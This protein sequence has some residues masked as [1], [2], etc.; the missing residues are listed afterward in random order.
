MR[1]KQFLYRFLYQQNPSPVLLDDYVANKVTKE[2]FDRA[3]EQWWKNPDSPPDEQMVEEA[4][5]V[6]KDELG[7]QAYEAA[8]AALAQALDACVAEEL[9]LHGFGQAGKNAKKHPQVIMLSKL[10]VAIRSQVA[11]AASQCLA[12][13]EQCRKWCQDENLRTHIQ[14][15]VLAAAIA[16]ISEKKTVYTPQEL[17]VL[18][19]IGASLKDRDVFVLV[20]IAAIVEII[21]KHL[22]EL[23]H[24]SDIVDS[25]K[26]LLNTPEIFASKRLAEARRKLQEFLE[27]GDAGTMSC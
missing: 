1:T 5:N 7:S 8:F 26:R 13:M 14:K 15:R 25:C 24:D 17:T 3:N 2:E 22:R 21:T 12:W 9:P 6:A 18:A 27:H 11:L 10:N 16:L 4:L 19:R 23:P 20:A